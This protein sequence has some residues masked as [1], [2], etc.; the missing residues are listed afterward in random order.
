MRREWIARLHRRHVDLP[1]RVGHELEPLG[2]GAWP[3][4]VHIAELRHE[5][6]GAARQQRPRRGLVGAVLFADDGQADRPIALREPQLREGDA[7]LG[8]PALGV[9]HDLHVP[10]RVPTVVVVPVV[11]VV[12]IGLH[13][14]GV[15]RKL[16]SRAAIVERVDDHFHPIGRRSLV[17]TR[18]HADDAGRL[19]VEGVDGDVERGVVVDEA[20]LGAFARRRAFGRLALHELADHRRVAPCR[21]VEAAVDDHG[22]GGR[23]GLCVEARAEARAF[24]RRPACGRDDHAGEANR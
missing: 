23:H 20:G 6:S 18:Q 4:A 15:H 3:H 8:A 19:A 12:A 2:R 24:A 17:T 11:E 1:E 14:H 22:R 5:A 9:L 7:E 13:A 21:L 16:V 10:H